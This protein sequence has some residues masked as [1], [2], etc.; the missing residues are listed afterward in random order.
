[1]KECDDV[2]SNILALTA[3]DKVRDDDDDDDDD[4]YDYD[5]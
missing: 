5:V 1:M 4:D 3:N 2:G